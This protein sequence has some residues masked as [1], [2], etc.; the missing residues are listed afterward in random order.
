[1]KHAHAIDVGENSN[2]KNKIIN[3]HCLVVRKRVSVQTNTAQC[4]GD[5]FGTFVLNYRVRTL[6]LQPWQG[7]RRQCYPPIENPMPAIG[8]FGRLDLTCFKAS[9][10]SSM[11]VAE[12]VRAVCQNV[13][14]RQ[15][16]IKPNNQRTHR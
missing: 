10:R 11:L 1:L 7:R 13:Y 5:T 8:L 12:Y 15:L 16:I 9:V 3:K 2:I 4:D 6:Q 14:S